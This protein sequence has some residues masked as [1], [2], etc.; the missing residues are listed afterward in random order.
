MSEVTAPSNA[1]DA[2]LEDSLVEEIKEVYTSLLDCFKCTDLSI[3]YDGNAHVIRSQFGA[4]QIPEE[5]QECFQ[6]AL[7]YV[8]Y[9]IGSLPFP[10]YI[11]D[12]V[13]PSP[14]E[15][16][17]LC[18][19]CLQK[20]KYFRRKNMSGREVFEAFFR[21]PQVSREAAFQLDNV[22]ISANRRY[23]R[24]PENVE[25]LSEPEKIQ[26]KL[27]DFFDLIRSPDLHKSYEDKTIIRMYISCRAAWA[28]SI[29]A[30]QF[31]A[32]TLRKR[33]IENAIFNFAE[34]QKKISVPFSN[35]A[36]IDMQLV[37]TV[38]GKCT[39]G[40]LINWRTF[41]ITTKEAYNMILGDLTEVDELTDL[42]L[43]LI[44][45]LA[46]YA[47]FR[48]EMMK[49]LANERKRGRT[50]LF[51]LVVDV[52]KHYGQYNRNK[53]VRFLDN[54]NVKVSLQ[55]K[56][57][58]VTAVWVEFEPIVE[59]GSLKDILFKLSCRIRYKEAPRAAADAESEGE[60]DPEKEFVDE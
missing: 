5:Y 31:N 36:G 29:G 52:L 38:V 16:Y 14:A 2:S 40:E 20:N 25:V 21:P 49:E 45:C 47:A 27:A 39:R 22:K 23:E 4:Y 6:L 17:K 58:N 56:D 48:P 10:N 18:V 60:E 19:E 46:R 13:W 59:N 42:H 50:D 7:F 54:G 55:F 34:H 24:H 57:S 30:F 28:V 51:N 44:E 35:T 33:W 9:K 11:K 3:G 41:G 53:G 26:K 8:G 12:L 1:D 32:K 37:S 15:A 43:K